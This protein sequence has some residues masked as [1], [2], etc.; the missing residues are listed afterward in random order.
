MRDAIKASQ[1]ASAANRFGL[2]AKPGELA[3]ASNDPRGWLHQ[4]LRATSLPTVFAAL[5]NS[6]DILQREYEYKQTK[7]AGKQAGIGQSGPG[8]AQ[9]EGNAASDADA[10]QL[11]RHERLAAQGGDTLMQA[12]GM[13]APDMR[14]DANPSDG[15]PPEFKRQRRELARSALADIDA[16]Y[17]WAASTDASFV[18]RLTRF[19]SNHFAVSVDKGP[20]RLYAA[21]MEREAIRPHVLGNFNDLLLAV[22]THPAMLRYLDNVASVGADS[23]FATRATRR[24]ERMA[25]QG[26]AAPKRK[27]GLNENLAREI[28]ELHTLGVDGG[29]KQTDVVEFARA[30]TGWGTL[31]PRDRQS[32]GGDVPGA[33]SST[34]FV[35]RDAAHEPGERVVLGKRYAQEGQV[36]GQA[37]L[38]DLALHP[39]T[40]QHLSLKLARHFVADEPPPTLVARMAQAYLGSRGD[41]T[42]VYTTLIDSPE[43]WSP[44]ARKF[45]TPDDFVVSAMRAGDIAFDRDPRVL[46]QLLEHLG[47]PVFNPRS[48]AG[49]PDTA[50]DWMAG[51]GLWKRIQAAEA[52]ADRVAVAQQNPLAAAQS[53]LGAEPVTGDFAAGLRRAGSPREGLALLFASPAFQWRA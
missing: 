10:R 9:V 20:A 21:P 53:S 19:W 3:A 31:M 14:R 32:G 11:R 29:Y 35:F 39:A 16:R 15:E 5:P 36:Q 44:S 41:L 52:L 30:I 26:N 48:P 23:T 18:E 8:N 2:G 12:P 45:K 46:T 49:Y 1:A 43:A 17:R 37:I 33:S 4:Q 25:A 13:R 47:Q 38:R 7:R 28:M 6:S 22:E 34:G 40:A 42:H 27:L 50:A 24:M 51:D